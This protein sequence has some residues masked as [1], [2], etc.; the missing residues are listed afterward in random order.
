MQTERENPDHKN[1]L[2]IGFFIGLFNF[3]GFYALLSALSKGHLSVIN[4]MNGLSFVIA[5]KLSII[6]YKEKVTFRRVVGIV[7]AVLA[8]VLLG[9]NGG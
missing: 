4:S 2:V 5:I 1:A 9:I 7:L 6:V 3:A 8:V